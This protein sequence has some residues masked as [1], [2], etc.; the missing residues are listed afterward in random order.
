MRIL[1][2]LLGFVLQCEIMREGTDVGQSAPL[3]EWAREKN[4]DL[5]AVGLDRGIH[6]PE[7]RKLFEEPL[8]C[9][10]LPKMGRLG[11]E[12]KVRGRGPK[13]AEMRRLRPAVK[14]WIAISSTAASTGIFSANPTA[15]RG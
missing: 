2:D 11:E 13:F 12:D 14:S 8:D 3:V 9:G 6:S 5:G 10:A 7:N 15:S 4:P 1:I